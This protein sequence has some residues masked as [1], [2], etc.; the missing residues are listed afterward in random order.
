MIRRYVL[1]ESHVIQY[2][3]VGLDDRLT[4]VEESVAILVRDV[5]QLRSRAIVQAMRLPGRR[6]CGSSSPAYSRLQVLLDSY[7]RG[8]K[9]FFVVDVVMTL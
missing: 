1:D 3:S 5:R 2:D 7:F 8:R 6:T 9:S 4:F